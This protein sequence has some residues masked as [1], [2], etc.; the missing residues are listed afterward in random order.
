MGMGWDCYFGRSSQIVIVWHG[1]GL[2]MLSPM[3]CVSQEAG[4]QKRS[5]VGSP[6]LS[7]C[8][9]AGIVANRA[10]LPLRA[11]LLA[12]GRTTDGTDGRV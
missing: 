9:G 1:S 4:G 11:R 3:V 10:S 6:E 2:A 12:L 8:V 7:F 5:R